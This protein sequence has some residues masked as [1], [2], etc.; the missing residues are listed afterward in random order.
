ML[1][2]YKYE[3]AIFEGLVAHNFIWPLYLS[4]EK[5]DTKSSWLNFTLEFTYLVLVP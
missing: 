4:Y 2:Q 5:S 3:K 1:V